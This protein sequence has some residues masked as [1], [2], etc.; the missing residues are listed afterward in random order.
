MPKEDR[1]AVAEAEG[2]PA[3]AAKGL[4]AA[5]AAGTAA[6]KG[7]PAAAAA[8]TGTV[9]T[10]LLRMLAMKV[11][12]ETNK[13]SLPTAALSFEGLGFDLEETTDFLSSAILSDYVTAVTE[14]RL[15]SAKEEKD[16]AKIYQTLATLG[17]LPN[18]PGHWK[19]K[20]DI[21]LTVFDAST[22][23]ATRAKYILQN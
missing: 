2:L 16:P 12:P 8:G 6:Q 18:L 14:A 15:V 4:P 13:A 3:A 7:L 20:M 9:Q 17:K 5:G 21:G 10:N 11:N 23:K 22:T 19:S 1:G